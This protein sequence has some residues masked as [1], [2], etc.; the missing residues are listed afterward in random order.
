M[1]ICVP[2]TKGTALKMSKRKIAAILGIVL[3]AVIS[4]S[5]FSFAS[6]STTTVDKTKSETTT[7]AVATEM[8][9]PVVQQ[10]PISRKVQFAY[11]VGGVIAFAVLGGVVVGTVRKVEDRIA[12]N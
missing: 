12:E 2:R 4:L 11:M 6:A 9:G 7:A 8:V 10:A 5:V 1:T 3:A